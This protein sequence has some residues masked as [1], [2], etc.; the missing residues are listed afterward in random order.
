M[1]IVAPVAFCIA[2]FLGPPSENAVAWLAEY[3]LPG[4][5]RIS[6]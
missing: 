3:H 1:K 2:A 5:V 6:Y 4:I